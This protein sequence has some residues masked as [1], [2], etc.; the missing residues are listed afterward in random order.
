M[1]M[2]MKVERGLARRQGL[3]FMKQSRLISSNFIF[4]PGRDGVRGNECAGML[5][6]MAALEMER[7]ER[8]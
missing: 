8:N 7:A 4:V 5:A 6:S 3:D 1:N 2:C